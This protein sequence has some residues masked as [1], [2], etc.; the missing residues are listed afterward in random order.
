MYST[1][2][3]FDS[4]APDQER[5][6]RK[7]RKKEEGEILDQFGLCLTGRKIGSRDVSAS[8]AQNASA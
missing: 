8:R 2:S 6:K 5:R 3:P 7:K 1:S 4:P